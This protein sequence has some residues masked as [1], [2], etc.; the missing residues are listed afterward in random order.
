MIR[1]ILFWNYTEKVKEEHTQEE[2]LRFMQQ[3]VATMNGNIEGLLHAEINRNF[4]G[5]YDLVFYA[6]FADEESLKKFM[7]HPLHVA[8]REKCKEIVTD[9]LCGDIVS[10][11]RR[12]HVRRKIKRT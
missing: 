8:H 12:R 2:S 7:N 1:H 3:S 10:E 4:A 5:G 6:E 11:L 9:R